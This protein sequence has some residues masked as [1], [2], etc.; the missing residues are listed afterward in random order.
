ME[1]RSLDK[2]LREKRGA[3]EKGK[4]TLQATRNRSQDIE[5]E[6]REVTALYGMVKGVS[7]SLTW[8]DIRPKIEMAIEQYLRLEDFS[9]YVVDDEADDGLRPLV[10]RNLA[11]S[12]GASW[13]TLSRY[14]QEH[15]LPVTVPHTIDSPERIE[16]SILRPTRGSVVFP[17]HVALSIRRTCERQGAGASGESCRA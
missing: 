9:I 2:D 17:A 8:E 13:E 14:L 3:Y 10:I 4:A 11:N 7:E 16:E 12:L 15:K 1:Y 6:Q 5:V